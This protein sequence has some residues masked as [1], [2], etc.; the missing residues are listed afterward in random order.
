LPGL[1]REQLIE[2]VKKHRPSSLTSLK[3][4][5]NEENI[6]IRE[7]ELLQLIKQLQSDGTIKLSIRTA[8][9][10]KEYLTDIW[11]T[12][13]FYLAIIVSI[14]ELALVVLNATTGASL[15]LRIIF[16]LA[17]LGIIPGFLTVLVIFPGGQINT[18]EKI[19]LSIFLSVL[20][21]I[22]VGVVLGLGQFFQPSNNIIILTIYV[23][24]ADIAAG[25]RSY[26]FLRKPS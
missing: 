8:A 5:L 12:W 21:S 4:S 26:N 19:A 17:M 9:S 15:F 3:K 11:S 25:Y 18:L 16:G 10:I 2:V 22:T 6:K 7:E 20:I 13:W 23:I 24:V 1:T 14:S